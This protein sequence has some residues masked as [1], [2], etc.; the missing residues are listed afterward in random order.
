MR[1][2]TYP[3]DEQGYEEEER[4]FCVSERCPVHFHRRPVGTQRDGRMRPRRQGRWRVCIRAHWIR[5]YGHGVLVVILRSDVWTLGVRPEVDMGLVG[6]MHRGQFA[7]DVDLGC[8]EVVE[9]ICDSHGHWSRWSTESAELLAFG[10]DLT[11]GED[12]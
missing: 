3:C 9:R 6:R 8:L 12:V 10:V 5:A 1:E 11:P 4:D 2:L 7:R